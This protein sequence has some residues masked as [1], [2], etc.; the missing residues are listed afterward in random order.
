QL[1]NPN[2]SGGLY[3]LSGNEVVNSVSNFGHQP[4]GHAGRAYVTTVDSDYLLSDFIAEVT[5][6]LDSS[7]PGFSGW[8]GVGSGT[9]NPN[10]YSAPNIGFDVELFGSSDFGGL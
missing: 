3:S 5:V 1:S 9:P 10:H 4:F 2:G 6:S 8:F 7:A